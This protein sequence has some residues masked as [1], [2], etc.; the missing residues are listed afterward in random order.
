MPN[1]LTRVPSR[2]VPALPAAGRLLLPLADAF[3]LVMLSRPA[4]GSLRATWVTP[5]TRVMCSLLAIAGLYGG[6]IAIQV[7]G[8]AWSVVGAAA[9]APATGGAAVAA[10]GAMQQM[11]GT[12]RT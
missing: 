2:P 4:T 7:G 1:R 8:V 5:A 10:V 12:R 6:V 11:H 9:L 3:M